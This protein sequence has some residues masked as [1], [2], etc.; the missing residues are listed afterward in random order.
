MSVPSYRDSVALLKER[1][2]IS[3]D[4]LPEVVRVPR[5]DDDPVGP[6]LFRMRLDG[7][8]LTG[9]CLRGLYVSRS[10]LK[11][12]SFAGS[13]LQLAAFNWSDL[14]ECDFSGV[15]LRQADL[16]SSVF[17]RCRFDGATLDGADMRGTRFDSC[18]FTGATLAQAKLQRGGTLAWLGV[19]RAQEALPLSPEQRA[20]ILWVRDAPE[21]PG[22]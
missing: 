21:A 6:S 8:E 20:T 13:E 17:S 14:I 9:L 3:G 10:E 18:S 12:V 7:A 15:D 11:R 16:R 19:G 1:V 2:E 5:P 22:G 4:A